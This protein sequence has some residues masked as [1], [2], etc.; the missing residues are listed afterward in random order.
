MAETV[1]PPRPPGRPSKINPDRIERI[2]QGVLLG[3]SLKAACETV[4]VHYATVLAWMSRGRQQKSGQYRDFYNLIKRAE[5]ELM[6]KTLDRFE[7]ILTTPRRKIKRVKTITPDGE[8]EISETVEEDHSTHWPQLAWMLERRWPE[9]FG[10][11][12]I[13][14]SGN[15]QHEV[16]GD[17]STTHQGVVTFEFERSGEPPD[18][19]AAGEVDGDVVARE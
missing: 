16:S 11:Q 19:E 17:V 12:R 5:S 13:D 18:P 3:M 6:H 10:R 1:L 14:V 7:K 9:H 2:R 8:T 15:I 4:D